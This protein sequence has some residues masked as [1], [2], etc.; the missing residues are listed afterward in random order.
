MMRGIDVSE[1]NGL[2]DWPLVAATGMKFA[3]VR[4][5]FG[6]HETDTLFQ[7]NV[8]SAHKAGLLC[9]A[10]HYSYALNMAEARQE[11][12]NCRQAIEKAGVLLELPVFFDME[13]ADSYKVR[14]GFSFDRGTVTGIC[15]T[16]LDNIGLDAGVYASYSWLCDYIDWPSLGCAVWNAQWGA[17]DDL[18]GYM[19][20]HT[21]SLNIGGRLFDG[22][23]LY[24]DYPPTS[25]NEAQTSQ[26]PGMLSEHFAANEFACQGGCGQGGEQMSP[27]LIDL[28]EQLHYNIGGLPLHINSGYRCPTHNAE[29]GGVKNSQHTQ[30]T[31]AD[32][33][34]PAGLTYGQFQ[35]YA[36]QLDFDAIGLYPYSDFLHLDVRCGGQGGGDERFFNGE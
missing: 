6:R 29:V 15:K 21:D 30:G 9:G 4:A 12:E 33:A 28:L 7:A 20:Q 23:I 26:K 13:D 19:W 24:A 11:A 1:N 8:E 10:Y 35:W 27:R 36:A 34:R 22:N 14:H 5:S 25:Q 3:I 31:A 2:V 17:S 16:F 18:R 32:V